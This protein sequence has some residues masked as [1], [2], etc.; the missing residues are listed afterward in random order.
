VGVQYA[1]DTA[2]FSCP[3][4]HGMRALTLRAGQL[5]DTCNS[6]SACMCD[7]DGGACDPT[8]ARF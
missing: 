1:S 4:D 2:D 3:T 6:A 8:D 5:L 7:A